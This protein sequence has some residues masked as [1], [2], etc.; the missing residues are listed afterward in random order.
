I[1]VK[2]CQQEP[3]FISKLQGFKKITAVAGVYKIINCGCQL[4]IFNSLK[5]SGHSIVIV[6]GR[7]K[8]HCIDADKKI[9]NGYCKDKKFFHDYIPPIKLFWNR[10]DTFYCC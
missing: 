10:N 6:F 9:K 1:V 2:C 5:K 4:S 8:F 7:L 3:V